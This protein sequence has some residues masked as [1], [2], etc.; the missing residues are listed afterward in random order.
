MAIPSSFVLSA[1]LMLP[2]V[3]VLAALMLIAGVLPP[4]ETTGEV[5]VTSITVPVAGVVQPKVPA[6]VP[7]VKTLPLL[8]VLVAGTCR[9][10]SPAG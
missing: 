5:P 1:A 8:V 4:D 6:V 7:T 10:P 2:A 9:L 3:E